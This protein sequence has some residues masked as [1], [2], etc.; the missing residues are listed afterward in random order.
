MTKTRPELRTAS[1]P[2]DSPG[3][4]SPSSGAH[5]LK[6]VPAGKWEWE[7]AVK[8]RSRKEG[9]TPGCQHVALL[10]STYADGDGSS[11][12]PSVRTLT[13]VSGKSRASVHEALRY[14][15]DKGW[16]EQVS[17][18]AGATRKASTYR[19]TIPAETR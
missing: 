17:R 6:A 10:L 16:V 3:G 12:R 2:S 14:L 8:T 15:R 7:Q 18:G 1:D 13:E 9:M 19:L 5:Q 4:N 11:I